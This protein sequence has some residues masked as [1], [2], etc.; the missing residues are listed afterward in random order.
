MK[1]IVSLLLMLAMVLSFA[2]VAETT[3]AR[4]DTLVYAT[5]TFGEKFSPFFAT[6][7]YD[8]ELTEMVFTYLLPS[9]RGGNVLQNSIEGETVN[10]NANFGSEMTWLLDNIEA[11]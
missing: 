2:G 7:A 11:R 4:T 9:D 1:K 10:Y 5:S 8:T 3:E 6:V